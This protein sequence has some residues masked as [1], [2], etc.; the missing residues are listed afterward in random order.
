MP[1]PTGDIADRL[2]RLTAH[3]PSGAPDPEVLWRR[4]RRRQ[5]AR[6]GAVL[7]A[8]VVVG[9]LG[10]TTVPLV[11]ERAQ[12][13]VPAGAEDRMVLPDVLRQPGAWEPT[14]L[15]APGR[16]SAVGTG[17][18][19]TLWP[20]SSSMAVWGVSAATGES[21]F[22]ELPGAAVQV[23]APALSAD[24]SRLAYWVTGEVTGEP[25]TM[26]GPSDS[27]GDPVVGVAVLDLDTGETQAWRLEPEHGLGTSG[28]AWSGD[29]LVWSAGAISRQGATAV[30][31]ATR[32][33]SWDLRTGEKDGSSSWI[34]PQP[35]G[36][37]P[38]G[39]VVQYQRDRAVVVSDGE[40]GPA[41]RLALP[42][43]DTSARGTTGASISPDGARLAALL[44]SGPEYVDG[45]PQALAV[46]RIVGRDVTLEAVGEPAAQAVLGWRSSTEVVVASLDDVE[47]GR[48]WRAERAW[49]V[50][51]TTGARS[52]LLDFE[53]STPRVAAD[54]WAA[55]VVPAPGPPFAPNPAL[56]GGIAAAL[57][58]L[59]LAGWAV[60]RRRRGHA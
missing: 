52:A 51:V 18:R 11:A 16:L 30:S 10:T 32:T 45:T 58:L 27:G 41:L 28:L 31:A 50:D 46:G 40:T 22:L 5:S 15:D 17:S 60:V 24:G 23:E 55:E 26:S 12:R 59:V 34:T 13:V 44:V 33:R 8:L 1:T 48:P 43:D 21:R 2:E 37:G 3:A 56:W 54:A 39:F 20:P 9:V 49:S 29:V 19:S 4:G 7:A 36:D 42:P 14:F 47:A 25:L 53:G 38:S 6:A 35:I 57:G